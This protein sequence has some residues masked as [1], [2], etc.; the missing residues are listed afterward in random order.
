MPNKD[1]YYSEKYID[2]THEYRHVIQGYLQ[3][4]AQGP[5]YVWSSAKSVHEPEP[6]ILLF[7]RVLPTQGWAKLNMSSDS[8]S[9][10]FG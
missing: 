6:H 5:P 1:I 3:A 2:E 7:K 4:G 9:Y 10:L 8:L